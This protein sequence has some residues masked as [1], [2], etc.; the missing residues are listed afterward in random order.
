MLGQCAWE[1]VQGPSK[2]QRLDDLGEAILFLISVLC[3]REE[4][5]GRL[6]RRTLKHSG[7]KN[8]LFFSL[9]V[10]PQCV[11]ACMCA[12]GGNAHDCLA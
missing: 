4:R 6:L 3:Q 11:S 7:Y 12:C 2:C 9:Q 1:D 5:G 8:S 10:G